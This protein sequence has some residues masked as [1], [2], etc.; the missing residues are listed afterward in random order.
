MISFGPSLRQIEAVIALMLALTCVLIAAAR[1]TG[2]LG[3]KRLALEKIGDFDQPLYVAQPPHESDLLF[4]VEKPGAIRVV[5]DGKTEAQ[6]FLDLTAVVKDKGSEQGLLS[7]AFPPD[8][9]QSGLFYVSYTDS[10]DSMRIV[11][12]ERRARPS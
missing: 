7:V 8:Y 11:E 5:A 3:P 9:Q 10:K 12:Y 4:V 6:P 1:S 2:D